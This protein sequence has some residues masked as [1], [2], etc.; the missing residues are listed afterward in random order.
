MNDKIRRKLKTR[1]EQAEEKKNTIIQFNPSKG[2]LLKPSEVSI[3]CSL[4]NVNIE[5]F[6]KGYEHGLVS[7]TLIDFKKSFRLGFRQA[8]L[9]QMAQSKGYSYSS[10]KFTSTF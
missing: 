7:N 10:I 2:K 5:E 3:D 4:A 6:K 1:E 9:E 8:K